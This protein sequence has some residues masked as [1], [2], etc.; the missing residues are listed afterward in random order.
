M[1]HAE[2][3]KI[4]LTALGVGLSDSK[5]F[6]NI[7]DHDWFAVFANTIESKNL[8]ELENFEANM[9]I[10]RGEVAEMIFR[11]LVLKNSGEDFF[12]SSFVKNFNFEKSPP[13]V[14]AGSIDFPSTA[15]TNL[16]IT[17]WWVSGGLWSQK[18]ILEFNGKS[19]EFSTPRDYAV[20]LQKIQ[21]HFEMLGDS[22]FDESITRYISEFGTITSFSK[23]SSNSATVISI[24]PIS[25]ISSISSASISH[26]PDFTNTDLKNETAVAARGGPSAKFNDTIIYAGYES[27]PPINLNPVLV[28]FTNGEQDWVRRDYETSAD[29]S[30]GYGLLF[31]DE[32]TVFA[33]FTSRGVEENLNYDFRRFTKYG[34]LSEYGEGEGKQIAVIA[35]INPING[36]VL[37][38]TYLSARL[39]GGE[40]NSLTVK[41]LQLIDKNLVVSADCWYAPR[42]TSRQSMDRKLSADNPPF[43]YTIE[44]T[45]DLRGAVWA[46]APGFGR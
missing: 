31:A 15:F 24:P 12:D 43:D 44:F 6:T 5:K 17:K 13:E 14:L 29:E 19:F 38:A 33:V 45:P 16:R 9:A 25:P 32:K 40:T 2:S 21:K 18:P 34:W 39:D 7:S 30:V 26:A 22:S 37:S 23:D 8:F 28:S 3:A 27:F 1:N 10:T 4:I 11:I 20:A 41:D 42:R 35:K 46:E 36:D